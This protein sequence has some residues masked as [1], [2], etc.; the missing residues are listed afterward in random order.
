M[1]FSLQESIGVGDLGAIDDV[2]TV[3]GGA[4]PRRR[5]RAPGRGRTGLA[6]HLGS[7]FPDGAHLSGGQWQKVALGRAMMRTT[8]PLLVLDEPTASLT[9]SSERELFDL[10][11]PTRATTPAPT[12]GTITLLI[13]HRFP[14]SSW[15]T[16]SS[17]LADGSIT[18]HGTHQELMRNRGTYAEL[19]ELQARS[20]R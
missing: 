6:T 10:L 18:E 15:P 3:L 17:V 1:E 16:S 20:Y 5:R 9:P 14:T 8:P 11:Q 2:P 7:S 12:S 4:G 19:Y 13:S